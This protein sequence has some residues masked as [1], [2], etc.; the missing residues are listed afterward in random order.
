MC[1]YTPICSYH[2]YSANRNLNLCASKLL[3]NLNS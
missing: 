1:T 3:S 2:K